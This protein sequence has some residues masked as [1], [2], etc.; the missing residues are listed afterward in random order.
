LQ[1][2]E[3]GQFVCPECGS[4]NSGDICMISP[5]PIEGDPWSWILQS[6]TCQDCESEIPS[7]LAERWGGMSLDEAIS[8][9]R[10]IY[11]D[12]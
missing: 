4:K 10:D 3:K 5:H 9:W 11:R 6:I 12:R 1:S 2:T 8:E 7:H